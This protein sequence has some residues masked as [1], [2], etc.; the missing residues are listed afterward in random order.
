MPL[1]NPDRPHHLRVMRVLVYA[2]TDG[3]MHF[4]LERARS[5]QTDLNKAEGMSDVSAVCDALDEPMFLYE[6][7]P[8]EREA[9]R[10]AL[11]VGSI[12]PP[13]VVVPAPPTTIE[14]QA[15]HGDSSAINP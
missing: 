12:A 14:E 8:Q 13:L 9:L 5:V 10:G 11:I 15:P 4:S 3:Q 1:P 6:P 2:S 7:T